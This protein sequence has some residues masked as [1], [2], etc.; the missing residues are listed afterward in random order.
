MSFSRTS[1]RAWRRG[2]QTLGA[3][4]AAGVLL[5]GCHRE[6]VNTPLA[7]LAQADGHWQVW[8]IR[9]P[10][11]SPAR[12]GQLP[13]DVA[14]M[15]W[16]PDGKS[17]LVNLQ[18]GR[19]FKVEAAS[20]KATALKTPAAAIFDAAVSPD[21]AQI[22]YSMSMGSSTDRNDLWTVDIATGATQKLTAIPG[23][24]HEPVWSRDGRSLYFLSGQG[25]PSHDIWKV[26]VVSRATA[27][28]T[29]NALFHF[30][31]AVRDDGVLAYSSNR[32]GHYDLWLMRE[33]GKPERLT[34]D[35]ALDARPSWSAD[36]DRLAFESTCDGASDVW[37][38]DL[39]SKAFTR[40]T[41]MPGG[42]RMP[43]WAPAGGAR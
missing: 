7:F 27:Q 41:R 5:A 24:Q 13:E 2:L 17:L 34:D 18:D 28:M 43:V 15:T 38:Y 21:G 25:G 3:I 32:G 12:V 36:G 8:W 35:E 39:S 33:S 42:A 30:D 37:T 22:A 19:W 4:V 10:G 16:F 11:A 29:V 40:V 23:L 6:P 1:G 31:V 26:D 20:G 9:T 14:R